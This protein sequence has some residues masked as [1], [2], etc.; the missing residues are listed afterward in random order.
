MRVLAQHSQPVAIFG[1]VD[2]AAR[3]PCGEGL[4]HQ[5]RVLLPPTGRPLDIGDLERHHPRR[6]TCRH[7]IASAHAMCPSKPSVFAMSR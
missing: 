4:P 5:I 6:R 3:K 2:L 1:L 7:G